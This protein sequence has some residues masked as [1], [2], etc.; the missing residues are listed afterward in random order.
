MPTRRGIN[1]TL[2]SVFGRRESEQDF[3][4]SRAH[5]EGECRHR[6]QFHALA[7]KYARDGGAK[8]GGYLALKYAED[9]DAPAAYSEICQGYIHRLCTGGKRIPLFPVA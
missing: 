9:E 7:L 2:S 8:D 5:S 4:A 3:H 6:L 1:L